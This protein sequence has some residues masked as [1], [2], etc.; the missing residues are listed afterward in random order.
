MSSATFV[1]D[2]AEDLRRVV[3]GEVRFD[4]VSRVLYSTDASIYEI[5]PIGV[6]IPRDT[7][8]VQ[9]V[10]EIARRAR[11]PVLPRGGG[12]SLAGQTVGHAVVLDFS[13]YMNRILEVNPDAGWARVQPGLVRNELANALAPRKLV[14]GPET[15]T[16]NRATIGGMIGN[17]SSGARSI[18]F[19]KT[20]DNTISVRALLAGG[21]AVTF[22]PL[23]GA[24]VAARARKEGPEGVL[25]R[26]IPEVVERTRAEVAQ[27][28]PK[29]QRRVGGYNLD[30]FPPGGPWN[31]AKLVVGS[32]GTLA[33]VTEAT[34]RIVPRLQATVLAVLHFDDIVPALEVTPEILDTHPTAVELI[35][36]I[37]LDMARQMRDYSTKMTFVEGDPAAL[38]VVEYAAETP[39][40]LLPRLDA[41]ES[42]MRRRGFGG[43]IVRA[44][45]PAAQAN[46]W[47]IRSSGVGLLLGMKTARKPVAFVEDTAVAPDRV[48]EYVRRFREI[49]ERHGTHASFYGHASVGLLHTRPILDLREA[50][51]IDTMRQIAEEISDLV[52]EFGG[53]MSGEHGDGLSRSH[54]NEKLFG[55]QIYQAF[56]EIK[57]AFDPEGRMNPGKVVDAPSM[58][59]SLRYG[60]AYRADAIHTVQ[61]FHRDGG[62]TNAVELCSGVGACR[63]PQGGTMCPSYMVTKEEAHSTRGRANALRAAISGRL[64]REAL[65]GPELYA[66]MD[67]CIGCKACKAECPSNVDMAKL[68]HEF[69]AHYYA[70]HGVP[71]RA[72]M[73]G[74]VAAAGPV[75]CATAPVSN[76]VIGTPPVRWLLHRALGIHPR[77]RLPA[78]SRQRFTRWFR[79]RGGSP[80][81]ANGAAKALPGGGRVMLLV[82]TFTEYYYPAI[83]Q[84]AVRVLEAAGCEVV[85]AP[86]RCCGRPM[87]SNGLL[88][89][90]QALAAANTQRLRPYADEGIPIVGLEPSCT[91]TLKDEYPDLAPGGAAD[92][93]ARQT[94][95]IEEFL[96]QLHA[97]GIDLPLG[98][99]ERRVLLHGHCHQRAMVGTQPSLAALRWLPGATVV[100]AD[101][102]CCGMAGSFGYEAEHYAVSLAMGE[103]ALFKAI[104]DL[105]VDALIVAAGASCRQQIL[106]GTGRPAVHLVEALAEALGPLDR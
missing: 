96:V 58:T 10:L 65:T 79:H 41:L 47:Q 25:Y 11:V 67:L 105:P 101:S 72:R 32:E 62:F 4:A 31:L 24:E 29:I 40:A 18:V 35:D 54:F 3:R 34:V 104:R 60:A 9:A 76:W 55:P 88:K 83:G 53:A 48:A 84:A 86:S 98:R 2:L 87:I 106:H 22:E 91:V 50:K 71:F 68:K 26:M 81:G 36:K 93:V 57:A 46:L 95:M 39:E 15:S 99:R 52:Q 100:E 77:R 1:Q 102:G 78:F 94:F 89:E 49:V 90:A 59:A 33:T 80:R 85:L 8:D 12:T 21:E 19:G 30:E 73:F 66:V 16:G 17:N 20:V 5:E 37:I 27:R 44:I 42:R 28:Y 64:P 23:G 56:R 75:G 92:Q 82:D 61:D 14:F 70:A 97:R 38:I 74:H 45:E 103:R 6:V 7:D 63:K 69:L 13:K 51:D 43:A